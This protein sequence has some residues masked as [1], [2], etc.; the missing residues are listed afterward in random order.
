LIALIVLG[1]SHALLGQAVN[2]TLLGT[3]TD[4]TGATVAHAKVSATET[5]TGETQESTTNE[6]G[7][8][9]FPDL[10]PGPY[11]VTVEAKGFK[12]EKRENI[13]LASNSSTRVDLSLVPGNVSETILVSTAPPLLQTDR[14]DI[15]TKIESE[16]LVD[17]AL[18]TN[19]N[20]QSMLNTV[21]GAA[22]GVYEHSQFFNAASSIQTEMNGL[23]LMGNLYQI[24]GIDDDQRTGLLQIII[25]PAEA[26]ASVDISTDNYEAELGRATGGVTN[27]TLKSGTNKIHG[28]AF[29]FIQNNDINARS[30]FQ[31]PLGHLSYNYFGGTVGGPIKKDKLFY[32]GDYL[33]TSDH[34]AIGSTFTIPDSRWFTPNS[35]GNIDLSSGYSASGA[36]QIYDPATGN[37]LASSPRTP[38]VNNQIPMARVNPV[39]LLILQDV[40]TAAKQYSNGPLYAAQTVPL[41]NPTNN[42]LTNVPFT[43]TM[44]S[45]DPK[46]DWSP[47]EKNHLSGRFSFARVVTFQAAAFGPFLGGPEGSGFEG[48][49]PQNAYS[50]GGSY[51]HIFS[52][53][54]FTEARVGVA[55]QRNESLVNDNGTSDATTLGIPGVNISGQPFTSGQAEITLSD[56]SGPLIGYSPSEPWVRAESNIDAVNIWT[57]IVG[58][59][60]FKGGVD[61]RRV[62]DDLLQDQTFGPR[63]AFT[64]SEPQTS[65]AGAI[66]TNVANDIASFLLD[67]PSGTGRDLNTF[68]PCYRQWW[69]FAFAS[70]KWQATPRMTLDIGLRWEFY[71]PATPK[72]AGGFSN[73]DP[74]NNTLVL[75]GLGGNA[76]NL[77]MKTQYSYFAPRFGI[78][79]RLTNDMVVRAGFGISYVPFPDN[80]YAYNYPIRANNAYNP[81]GSSP[82]TPAVLA[83]GVTVA[84]FQAGFPAP[85]AIP[86]PTNGI[87]AVSGNKLLNSSS[88]FYI[89]PNFKNPYA[90][91]WNVAV[92]RSFRSNLSLQVAYVA[93]HGT[94]MSSG[95]N[96]NDPSTYDGGAASDPENATFGRTASTTEYY[97]GFSSNYQ[98]LQ[99]QLTL[100]ASHG[101]T[102]M[103]AYTWGKG[104]NYIGDPDSGVDFFINLRRNYGPDDQDRKSNFEQTM[105]YALPFGRGHALLNSTV[106]DAI[107]GGWKITGLVS[108]ISGLPLTVSA[109]GSSLNTPGTEQTATLLTKWSTT[110]HVGAGSP[111]FN[112]NSTVPGTWGQPTGCTGQTPGSLSGS[113]YTPSTCTAPGLGNTGRGQFRGP[114]YIQDNASIFKK[115]IIYRETA[116][117]VRVDAFQLSNTPQ[118]GNPNTSGVTA[119]SFGTVTSTLGSGQ[120]SVN[121]VGGGRVVQGS[122][123]FTF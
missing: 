90:D 77:G 117:E 100:R 62:R 107:L 72:V 74:A 63:G 118:F 14:A 38:F 76:S 10:L 103:S 47:N 2:A 115:F 108:V 56:F 123:K 95:Q 41:N 22:P 92:E 44:N 93:N 50:T 85:V 15:S 29:E 84:T 101:L 34:E 40:Y 81:T 46:V 57:K 35:S 83:D 119:A 70:D 8:Y 49:G 67:Q 18:G 66:G 111:W 97:L 42:Y 52:P 9:T 94:H 114:G 16:D 110:H 23:P 86:I 25:P 104:L 122:A 59:H 39:S 1:F 58:N 21:P 88:F 4:A 89:P 24:E 7:N 87:I 106:G 80:G 6:S 36:G 27:V 30:Y 45:F 75:A 64:F 11:S 73:Y 69:F 79:Y 31:G 37:G 28:S 116:V 113:V 26:I 54:F 99:S 32:F 48:T 68:F 12:K 120:G 33:H 78:S 55:H 20:F 121:G 3:V 82:Y 5:S 109:S 13:D 96:I 105:T 71:P 19:R 98:A 60:T 91:S 65:N 51:T 61:L 53:T 112:T 17:M 43:K 102:F